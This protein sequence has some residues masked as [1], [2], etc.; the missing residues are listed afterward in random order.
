MGEIVPF[1][2]DGRRAEAAPRDDSARGGPAQI[3]FFLGVRYERH[4][5]GPGEPRRRDPAGAAPRR[6]RRRKRA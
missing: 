3:L 6:Q 2:R 4:D 1:C 5:D